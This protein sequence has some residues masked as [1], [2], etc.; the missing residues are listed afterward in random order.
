[1]KE[2]E[3]KSK[4]YTDNLPLCEYKD[5]R[6]AFETGWDAAMDYLANIPYDEMLREFQRYFKKKEGR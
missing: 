6:E 1:M 5:A 4:E 2:K 3:K